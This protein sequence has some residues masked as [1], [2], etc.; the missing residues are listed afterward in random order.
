[1]SSTLGGG[2]GSPAGSATSAGAGING[3]GPSLQGMLSGAGGLQGVLS[4]TGGP[5]REAIMKQVSPS[6]DS[7]GS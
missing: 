7:G 4:G 5:G 6:S 1:M 2:A 3:D